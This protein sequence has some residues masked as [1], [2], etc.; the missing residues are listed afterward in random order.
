MRQRS[1]YTAFLAVVLC[2]LLCCAA[3]LSAYRIAG[4]AHANGNYEAARWA[5]RVAAT[6]GNAKAQ[7]N[8]AGLYA[9]GLGGE[10]N[11]VLAAKWFQRAA[12]QGVTQA[13][14]NLSNFYEE[15]KGVPRDAR[16]AVALLESAASDGDIDAA[17]NLGNLY[18]TGRDDFPKNVAIGIEWYRK[19][20]DRGFASAQYN[21]GSIF[22]RGADVPKDLA[23]AGKWFTKAAQ[24]GHAKAQL[25]LDVP[26][27]LHWLRKAAGKPSTSVEARERI[28][29]ICSDTSNLQDSAPCSMP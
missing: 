12:D 10:R 22:A 21:L 25:D 17:F 11:D 19:A 24:Q 14:F 3:I 23:E 9:E 27:G 13:K 18:S 26:Q 8:L 20:A 28:K 16:K 1:T 7:N 29:A 6:I 15:G 4:I 5:L 2:T